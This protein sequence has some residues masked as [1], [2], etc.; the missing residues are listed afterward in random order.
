M[1]ERAYGDAFNRSYRADIVIH[2]MGR[3]I[4]IKAVDAET[5]SIELN[6]I[7]TSKAKVAVG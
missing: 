2:T 3:S 4:L 7:G 1:H 6:G 5:I